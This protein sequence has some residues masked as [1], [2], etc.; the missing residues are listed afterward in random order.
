MAPYD[1]DLPHPVLTKI[2]DT[3]TEPTF[4]TILV[5]HVELNANAA[6]IYSTQGDGLHGH[7]ALTINADNYKQHSI[8]GVALRSKYPPP[9]QPSP[10]TRTRPRTPKF[11]KTIDSTRPSSQNSFYGIM[12]MPSSA[13]SSSLQSQPSSSP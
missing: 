8:G 11:Q 10:P 1:F 5:T 6:S 4:A 7:L 13:I 9:L 2:G 12:Q 3:N